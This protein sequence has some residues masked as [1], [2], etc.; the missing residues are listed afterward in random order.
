LKTSINR[1]VTGRGGVMRN[2]T[3][4]TPPPCH[5]LTTRRG[6]TTVTDTGDSSKLIKRGLNYD[7]SFNFR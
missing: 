7:N 1:H 5:T 2:L 3:S 6:K 4:T